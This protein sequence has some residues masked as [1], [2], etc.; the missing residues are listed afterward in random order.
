MKSFTLRLFNFPGERLIK[1]RQRLKPVQVPEPIKKL[2]PFKETNLY[3]ITEDTDVIQFI[4]WFAFDLAFNNIEDI[5]EF[6][7]TNSCYLFFKEYSSDPILEVKLMTALIYLYASKRILQG[8]VADDTIFSY[9]LPYL[10]EA[11]FDLECSITLIE[12]GYFK[13]SLQTLRNVIELTLAHA[14]FAVK[15]LDF[16]DLLEDTDK[17]IPPL[18]QLIIFLRSEELLT[19]QLEQQI[20]DAYKFLSGAV[21]SEITKLNT[22]RTTTDNESFMDW[23][24]AFIKAININMKTIIRMIEIGI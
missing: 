14:Y 13:Q 9:H 7:Y 19:A 4:D 8:L 11:A 2:L 10:A 17:R 21:H 18:R 3:G 23:Y 22:G 5:K 6:V 24:N 15:D 20:F 16:E 12:T 1:S